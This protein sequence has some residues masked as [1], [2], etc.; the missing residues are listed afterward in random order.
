[1]RAVVSTIGSPAYGTLKYLVNIIRPTLN[2]NKQR[3]LNSSTFVEEAKE[4]N[5]SPSEIQTSFDVVNLYPSVPIDKAVAVV[6]EILNHDINDLQKRTKLTLTDIHKLIELCLSTNYF[7]FDNRVGIFENS[8]SIGLALMVVISEAF[9]Q[10][11]E[12]R[13][14]QEAL[15]TNL[16]PLT[17]KRYA[18]DSHARF[19]TEH[20]SHS[21]LNILNK[22][23]KAIKYPLEK[24]DQSR[25]L[26][27]SDLTIINTGTGKYEFKIHRKNAITNV[28]IKPHSYVNP[29]LIRGIF[30]GFVS[31]AK[32][33]CSEKY[34]NDELNVLVDM[35]VENGHDRN[36][37][38]SIIRENKHQGPKYENTDSNI[39]KLPWIPIIGP[40]RRKER[41]KTGC[42]VIFTSAARLKNILCNDRSKLLPNSCPGA[43][44]LSCDFGGEHIGET[45]KRVL[46]RSIEHQEWQENGKRRVQLN[47]PKNVVGGLIGCTQKHL[48]N[49]PTY[50]NV[51]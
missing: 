40:K 48:Q 11:L 24:E 16:A 36:H 4:W 10:R 35:S 5:I 2:K 32:K 51:K 14:L 46:T 18:D 8:G 26:N 27:F 13:A 39:V 23:N 43:Y 44:E 45:K 42:R 17:Y 28:Q 30:K 49:C 6:I 34:L 9:L 25:K 37:L 29:A 7:F 50:T 47:I 1:M 31:R 12:D 38:Y 3:V 15:A 20:Q 21:F 19:E 22:Q 33:L 41:R